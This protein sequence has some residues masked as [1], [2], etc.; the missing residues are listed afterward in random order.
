MSVNNHAREN[1]S[2]Y[3]QSCGRGM[4]EMKEPSQRDVVCD[5]PF[6][7]VHCL[8]LEH[9]LRIEV[10]HTRTTDLSR[11]R[12]RTVERTI[13]SPCSVPCVLQHWARGSLR[14]ENVI[15][16]NISGHSGGSWRCH[17]RMSGNMRFRCLV[18]F[19][20]DAKRSLRRGGR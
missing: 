12:V 16:W 2:E 13:R 6:S 10:R 18:I 8:Q 19:C 14:P 3:E 7:E 9:Q 15:V 20:I 11:D 5:V 4:K 17:R 1:K